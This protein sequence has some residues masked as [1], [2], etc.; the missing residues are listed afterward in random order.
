[1]KT[2]LETFNKHF[3]TNYKFTEVNEHLAYAD[4]LDLGELDLIIDQAK[5]YAYHTKKL[6][7]TIFEVVYRFTGGHFSTAIVGR[8]LDGEFKPFTLQSFPE[9]LTIIPDNVLDKLNSDI[10]HGI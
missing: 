2:C 4:L 6:E 5:L 3:G 10:S 8:S 9:D 1:M 7:G